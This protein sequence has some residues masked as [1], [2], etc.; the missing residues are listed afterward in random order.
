MEELIQRVPTL[1]VV[2][3]G[4]DG[5]TQGLDGDTSAHEHGGPAKNTG[6]AMN[7]GCRGLHD[8][9]LGVRYSIHHCRVERLTDR[10]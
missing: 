1:Q 7:Y 8:S 5:D 9:S 4:L 2:K 6:I 10:A 3:Q